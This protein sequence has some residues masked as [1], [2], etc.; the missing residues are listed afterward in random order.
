MT[1]TLAPPVL[2]GQAVKVTYTPPAESRLRDLAGN[3]AG[4]F[5][6]RTVTN[7]T[8]D[9]S[10][11]WSVQVDPS[12]IAEAG[13]TAT[14]TVSTGTATFA[15][16]QTITVTPTGTA[17]AGS[18]F[19]FSV[20]GVSLTA[21]YT[22]TLPIGATSVMATVTAV[23]DPVVDAAETIVLTASHDGAEI[24]VAPA[25]T[26]VDDDTAPG[27]P[28][29]AA[30][31]GDMQVVLSWSGGASGTQAI[32]AHQYRRKAG[33]AEFG[34]WLPIDDSGP[35]GTNA[36]GFTVQDLD[37]GIE[38]TFR[39]RAVS[40]AGEGDPSNEVTA[41][42]VAGNTGPT[43]T[44]PAAFSAAENQTSAGT[45]AAADPDTGDAVTYAITG[46]ADQDRFSIDATSGELSF[47]AAPDYENPA[48]LASTGP[49]ERRE[50]QRVRRGGD[51][52]RGHGDPGAERVADDHGDGDRRRR[53]PDRR[54]HR[55]HFRP[56]RVRSRRR[57]LRH[58]GHR[59]GHGDVQRRGGGGRHERRQPAHPGTR[60]RRG[61][62]ERGVRGRRRGVDDARVQLHGGRRTTRTRTA[63]RS[64]P[65][66]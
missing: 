9:E 57:H 19:T 18:D 43:F 48:D 30:T 35:T 24:G 10:P 32:T 49:G 17:T 12:E 8:I 1:L 58:R 2:P 15:D 59:F 38:Y 56:R 3:A 31:A 62:E 5:S 64:A 65:T 41:T 22:V 52:D 53:G 55:A 50:E 6:S 23:D 54:V 11:V 25:L 16:A 44:S 37:N 26:I 66:P 28:V 61:V 60:L 63:S 4:G 36:N 40:D 39:V 7:E 29:L 20:G 47:V 46:G 27:A 33:S 34:D 42:P 45:V 14:L 13:G 51:R 21:P